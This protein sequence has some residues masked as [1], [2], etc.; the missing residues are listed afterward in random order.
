MLTLA[1]AQRADGAVPPLWSAMDGDFDR[2]Y[3]A[4]IVAAVLG[5][6]AANREARASVHDT[7]RWSELAEY[8]PAA[9]EIAAIYVD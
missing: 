3:H 6:L 4:T 9:P 8:R 2:V 7:R 1:A 5:K